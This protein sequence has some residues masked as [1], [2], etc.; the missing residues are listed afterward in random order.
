MVILKM[1]VYKETLMTFYVTHQSSPWMITYQQFLDTIKIY[2]R[3]SQKKQQ[4]NTRYAGRVSRKPRKKM[5]MLEKMGSK[6]T[7]EP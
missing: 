4:N 7:T 3:D 1:R 2:N 6:R 5:K